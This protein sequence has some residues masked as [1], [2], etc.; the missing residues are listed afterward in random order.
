MSAPIVWRFKESKQRLVGGRCDSC[1]RA[2]YP[3]TYGCPYC[4]ARSVKEFVLPREGKI[5]SYSIVYSA[6]DAARFE[7]PIV[8][9]LVDLGVAR[10]IAEITDVDPSEISE[11]MKVEAVLRKVREEGESGVIVYALKFR[12]LLVDGD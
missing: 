2:F 8:L 4:G 1:G 6:T 10:V 3:L 11:G 12:P 7:T 5:V 9:A